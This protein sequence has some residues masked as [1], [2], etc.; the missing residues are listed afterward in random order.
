M[1]L[2]PM[3]AI[4][5]RLMAYFVGHVVWSLYMINYGVQIPTAMPEFSLMFEVLGLSSLT[6][7]MYWVEKLAFGVYVYTA[8][9]VD[10]WFTVDGW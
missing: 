1:V 6:L 5:V 2:Q 4:V 9:V 3:N 8:G 10:D 7:V